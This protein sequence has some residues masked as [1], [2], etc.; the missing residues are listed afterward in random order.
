M[1]VI[2]IDPG[3][4][5]CG[6]GIVEEAPGPEKLRH[7]DCGAVFTKSHDRLPERLACIYDALRE[8]IRIYEPAEAVIE[9]MF[10]HKNAKSAEILGHARGVAILACI[11]AGLPIAEYS[12]THIKQAVVGYGRAD[13]NQVAMMVK[14]LLHLRETAVEDAMD[15]L[16]GAVC[17]LNSR[18][19]RLALE[20]AK[21]TR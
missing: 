4:H 6:W 14:A 10:H 16:A 5:V 1:R 20:K 19:M 12:P 21:Q 11:H 13:K 18:R 17:H 2:G 15:A 7:I 9:S 8:C 3:S